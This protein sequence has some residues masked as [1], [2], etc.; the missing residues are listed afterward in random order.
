M[1]L[2]ANSSPS[3]GVAHTHMVEALIETKPLKLRSGTRSYLYS[4]LIGSPTI[5]ALARM[6]FFPSPP[7]RC[8]LISPSCRTCCICVPTELLSPQWRSYST[9]DPKTLADG[10]RLVIAVALI[11]AKVKTSKRCL[12][13]ARQRLAWSTRRHLC[14]LTSCSMT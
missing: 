6:S 10:P 14:S 11:I 12:P 8:A 1:S 9:S 7:F 13:T 3:A 4:R 2:K 5:S